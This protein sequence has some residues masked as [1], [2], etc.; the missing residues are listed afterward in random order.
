[1]MPVALAEA[2]REKGVSILSSHRFEALRGAATRRRGL[3]RLA[4]RPDKNIAKCVQVCFVAR[5]DQKG[6]QSL[7][8][9]VLPAI[10]APVNRCRSSGRRHLSLAASMGRIRPPGTKIEVSGASAR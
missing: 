3:H 1:M 2:E 8:N 6:F 9:V 4:Y 5:L 7:R 10:E